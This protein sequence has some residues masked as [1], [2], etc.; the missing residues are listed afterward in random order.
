MKP[1]TIL[2]DN[3]Q[4]YRVNKD[5]SQKDL[6]K[7]SG[8]SQVMISVIERKK[9]SPSLRSMELLSK[10]MRSTVVKLLTP[11]IFDRR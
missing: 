10:A 4:T 5:M 8:L 3:I 1:S 6:A 9:H 11:N 7:K 2:S